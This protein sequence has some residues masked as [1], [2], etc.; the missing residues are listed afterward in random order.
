MTDSPDHG[1]NEIIAVYGF[2][3]QQEQF[4]KWIN[5]FRDRNPTAHKTPTLAELRFYNLRTNAADRVL[6]HHDLG[7]FVNPGG[8]YLDRFKFL[9]PIRAVLRLLGWKPSTMRHSVPAK[10]DQHTRAIF[11]L[12]DLVQVIPLAHPPEFFAKQKP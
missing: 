12:G 10:F 3:E 4:K 9:A 7:G 8:A 1:E 6:V 11:G 5:T 2:P